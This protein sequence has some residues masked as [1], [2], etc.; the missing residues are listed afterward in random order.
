MNIKLKTKKD[1]AELRVSG[2]ILGK[3]L[4][5][6]AATAKEGVSLKELDTKARKFIYEAGA[7]PAFLGYKPE[8]SSYPYPASICASLNSTVVHGIPTKY[9]LKE[10]D[11]LG[12]DAG[13]KYKGYYTD[14]AITVG[15]GKISKEADYLMKVTKSAL[16]S[17][18]RA[19]APGRHLGDIGSAIQNVV[20]KEK[21][22]VIRGLTGHGVGF[23]L[24]EDPSIPNH[25]KKG[26]GMELVPGLVI[27]IEPMVSTGT[28]YVIQ[29]RDDS[30]VTEDGSLSA[31]FEHTIVITE[32]GIE[33]LTKV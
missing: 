9:V 7:E 8:G 24:H 22:F 32:S 33:V 26:Q 11:I 25:G 31:H 6:L 19:C 12:I 20:E 28:A 13:V 15:I 3:T 27:A 29:E 21:L 16:E 14:S 17:G 10:G 18:I 1:I 30:F 23:D 5:M 4:K 2:R